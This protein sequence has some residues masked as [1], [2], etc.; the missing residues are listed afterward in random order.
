MDG[1]S[2]VPILKDPAARLEP[3]ALYWHYPHY[4]P[5][6][7]T[8]PYGSMRQGDW[9]FLVHYEDMDVEVYNLKE[10]IG[11]RNNLARRLPE[12]TREL[13][14]DFF[15]WIERVDAQMPSPNPDFKPAVE[16]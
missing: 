10:D 15:A 4:N 6:R 9:R 1:R 8:R 12:K 5:Q 3:R 14:E 16:K 13:R 7:N 2:L 11:E